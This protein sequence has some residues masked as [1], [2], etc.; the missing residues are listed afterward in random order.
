MA[1]GVFGLVGFLA[2]IIVVME[3]RLLPLFAWYRGRA[4]TGFHGPVRSPHAMHNR[5]P[6]QVVFIGWL[7]G[8]PALAL[9]FA[10]GAVPL[11]ATG[12]WALFAAVTISFLDNVLVVAHA[13]PNDDRRTTTRART[14][15]S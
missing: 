8:V 7:F 12:A 2:Q 9:G 5:S 3:T 1:Y 14:A 15:I 13:W 6:Q 10:L 11:L 4:A